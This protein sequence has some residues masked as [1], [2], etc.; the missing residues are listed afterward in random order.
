MSHSRRHTPICGNTLARSEK[1][2]KRLANRCWR[3]IVRARIALGQVELL[4]LQ[5][6]VS[7]VWSF[8]KDGKHRFMPDERLMRK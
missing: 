1:K 3:R 7:N 2:D 4:P 5:R 8:A 6:E